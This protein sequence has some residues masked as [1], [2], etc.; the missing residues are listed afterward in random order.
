METAS[1]IIENMAKEES[2]TQL[3]N[4]VKEAGHHLIE[5]NRGYEKSQLSKFWVGEGNQ[6]PIHCV[7]FNGSI[8]MAKLLRKDLPNIC[9]PVIYANYPAF[10]C[11]N[12]YPYFGDILFND[13][14]VM[15][16]LSELVRQKFLVYGLLGKEATIFLRPDSGEKTFQAQLVDFSDLERFA[17]NQGVAVNNEMVVVSTPKNIRWEGRFV[18]TRWE[19]IVAHSTY[20]YQGERLYVASAPTKARELCEEVIK[21]Q[22]IP[23]SVYCVDV[24]EDN[25][26][27]CWLLELTSFSSAGLYACDKRN[28]VKA[29]TEIA[30]ED[31]KRANVSMPWPGLVGH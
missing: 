6:Y 17:E 16:P 21:R 18:V 7:V 25:D 14:Y 31:F 24:C 1:W 10:L 22:Y 20:R 5:L 4:A 9:Q 28:I 13:R 2:F 19:E 11:S 8:E 30:Y 3:A 29:V 12:Y 26:G 23:D 27:N 15:M